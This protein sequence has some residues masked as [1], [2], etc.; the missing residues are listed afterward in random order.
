M[1]VTDPF[2]HF[3][4]RN[5][6]PDLETLES[7]RKFA[8]GGRGVEGDEAVAGEQHTERKAAQLDRVTGD[9][10]DHLVVGDSM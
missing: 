8:R 10:D 1:A 2:D 4:V 3:V 9:S 7:R 5:D 6:H